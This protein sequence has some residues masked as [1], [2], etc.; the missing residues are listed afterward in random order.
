MMFVVGAN[1]LGPEGQRVLICCQGL[2]SCLAAIC[3]AGK[4]TF[5]HILLAQLYSVVT[6]TY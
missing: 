1:P 4:P 5:L 3:N 6:Q 2:V